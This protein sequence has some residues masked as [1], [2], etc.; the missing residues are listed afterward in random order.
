MKEKIEI[1]DTSVK[2]RGGGGGGHILGIF[3]KKHGILGFLSAT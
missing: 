1:R 3:G 2:R